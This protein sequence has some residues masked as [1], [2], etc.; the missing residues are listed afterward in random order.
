M[1]ARVDK[2]LEN[3]GGVNRS[4][5]ELVEILLVAHVWEKF[6]EYGLQRAFRRLPVYDERNI[7]KAE[8]DIL[9]VNSE[10]AMAVEVKKKVESEAVNE[11]IV[12]MKR[13]HKYPPAEL[14]LHPKVKVL[15]A[16]AGGFVSPEGRE[17]A[18]QEGFYVLE[19]AGE[20]VVR[21]PEP[22][23]FKPKEW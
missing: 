20:S 23:G 2:L 1:S 16:V 9:L 21:V 10:W 12:R 22:E 18:H 15:G 7:P 11:H 13:I 3:V 5:G 4:I 8:V 17:A 6:P 14:K 19:L